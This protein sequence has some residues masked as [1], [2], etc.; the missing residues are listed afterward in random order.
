MPLPEFLTRHGI[1]TVTDNV[2]AGHR[3]H[4]PAGVLVALFEEEILAVTT[5][6]P[7][8]DPLPAPEPVHTA[9]DAQALDEAL[10]TLERLAA[11]SPA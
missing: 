7:P 2:P 3:V 8:A 5:R 9:D 11:R 10:A 1:T 4:P 6:R